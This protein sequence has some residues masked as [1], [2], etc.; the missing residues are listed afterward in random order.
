MEKL[1]PCPF[2]GAVPDITGEDDGIWGVEC[3]SNDPVIVSTIAFETRSEAI[4]AWNR[5]T[6]SE[7]PK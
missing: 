6:P 7:P 5:R 1:L 3:S 4:A 2:C